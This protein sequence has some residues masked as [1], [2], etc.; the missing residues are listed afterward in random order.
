MERGMRK[1]ENKQKRFQTALEGKHTLCTVLYGV[2]VSYK[3]IGN[4]SIPFCRGTL[5]ILALFYKKCAGTD[6]EKQ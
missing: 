4:H 6:S 1:M 5:F 2:P 3:C